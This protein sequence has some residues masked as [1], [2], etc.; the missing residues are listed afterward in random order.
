MQNGQILSPK[1]RKAMANKPPVCPYDESP[2]GDIEQEDA[3]GEEQQGGEQLHADCAL[4]SS[5]RSVD[6][7]Q[8]SSGVQTLTNNSYTLYCTHILFQLYDRVGMRF[9]S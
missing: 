9:S 2:G 4:T 1:L 6:N 7:M 3:D 5:Q 8:Q